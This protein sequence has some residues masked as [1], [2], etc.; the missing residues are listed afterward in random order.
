MTTKFDPERAAEAQE[1]IE[2]VTGERFS[3]SFHESLKDGVLLC[4]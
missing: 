1:W 3:G 2:T 4:K